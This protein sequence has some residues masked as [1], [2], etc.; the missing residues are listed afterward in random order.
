MKAWQFVKNVSE[1]LAFLL[2]IEV[3]TPQGVVERFGTH[4]DL[5]GQGLLGKMLNGT[6]HLE[7]L[8][9][10][11]LPVQSEHR[12]SHLSVIRVALQGNI[13]RSSGIDDALVQDGDL[14]GIII[15]R[16]VGTFIERLTTGCHDHRALRHVIGTQR[17]HVGIRASE[18]SHKDEL[19]FLGHLLGC[20][21]RGVIEFRESIF[22]SH[23]RRNPIA[24]QIVL[25]V[26]T[27][28]FHAG[29]EYAAISHGIATHIVEKAVGMGFVVIIQTVGPDQFDNGL[30]FHL[31]LRDIG[32]IHARGVALIPHVEAELVFL[33]RRCQIIHVAHHQFPV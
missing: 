9:E 18:L 27:E 10:I 7:I 30:F 3:H 32:N 25:K 5:R 29:E 22:L 33:H 24:Q 14:S 6:A 21:L 2:P 8:R 15:H 20:G 4:G 28:W 31:R 11:V 16:I 1:P 13:H 12:L 17:N 26:L 23:C 19:V